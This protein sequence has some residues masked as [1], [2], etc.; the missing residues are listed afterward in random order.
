MAVISGA[1][2]SNFEDIMSAAANASTNLEPGVDKAKRLGAIMRVIAGQ[3][4][5]GA[6]EMKDMSKY[7]A[8]I[9]AAAPGFE[10]DVGSNI[11]KLGA[12][13][14]I[15]RQ[16]GGAASPVEAVRAVGGFANTLQKS[17]RVKA[18]AKAGVDVFTNDKHTTFK[19]PF[20]LIRE[21]LTKTGGK[22]DAMN[23]LF[24][25]VI[26]AK[27][28]TGLTNRFNQAGGGAEGLKAVDSY[29]QTFMKGA[30]L[31][32]DELKESNK[33][34]M[35]SDAAKAQKFQE[36]LDAV[37]AK[38]LS[39]VI[40]AFERLE[41]KVLELVE[42]FS[43]VV[44]WASENPGRAIALAVGV[45]IARAGLESTLRHGI[46]SVFKGLSGTGGV[47]GKGAPGFMG[48][49]GLLSNLAAGLTI[50]TLAVTTLEAGKMVIS[51]FFDEQKKRQNEGALGGVQAA[52]AVANAHRAIEEQGALDPENKSAL[53]AAQLALQ[54]KITDAETFKSRYQDNEKGQQSA[55]TDTA[56]AAMGIG[57]GLSSPQTAQFDLHHLQELKD[58][59]SQVRSLLG[60]IKE[61]TLSVRIEGG[62]PPGTAP[63]GF[64]TGHTVDH[65]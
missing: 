10:G 30:A 8:I 26:G 38:M 53:E 9:A 3:G 54:K 59:M 36:S 35:E 14:Q 11:V 64:R 52:A 56:L 12:L 40:P 32:E 44:T 15:A 50:A 49:M 23:A 1:T 57:N 21:A 31:S 39:G 48:G 62:P 5:L 61:G 25:N 34:R 42:S 7:M 13:A 65:F 63:G 33:R 37:I 24:A 29:I 41:P 55:M 27:A 22:K 47:G 16:T 28:V 19:D 46:E 2:N 18:F 20:E 6:V 4:K 43:R 45:S 17:A 51:E 60:D 58:Q